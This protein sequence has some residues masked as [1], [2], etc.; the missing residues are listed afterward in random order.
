MR[1]KKNER[2]EYAKALMSKK[3]EIAPF[4]ITS[5]SMQ[6]HLLYLYI[7]LE[8]DAPILEAL[9]N[10]TPSLPST[11]VYQGLP[12]AVNLLPLLAEKLVQCHW[13]I[14]HRDARELLATTRDGRETIAL[15]AQ[16]YNGPHIPWRLV[17]A[18]VVH[19][20][21]SCFKLLAQGG[22][23]EAWQLTTSAGFSKSLYLESNDGTW[24]IA[25][26]F[27]TFRNADFC[28]KAIEL[29]RQLQ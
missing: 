9:W 26:T 24:H 16:P 2:D 13:L 7:A 1:V 19:G 14:R 3:P 27:D 12:Y 5:Q 11:S 28:N 17:Q 10:C 29:A 18:N 8:C 6:K 22:E 25:K 15:L 23:I 4:E 21:L 20:S